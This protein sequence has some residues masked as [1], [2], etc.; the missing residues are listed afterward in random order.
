MKHIFIL[1]PAAG[2][3]KAESHILPRILHAVK[4]AGVEYEIHRTLNKGDGEKYVR[5]AC[6]KSSCKDR[7]RF[8]AVGGDGTLNEVANGAY[9]FN[10][11][12]ITVIPAGTDNDFVRIFENTEDFQDISKQLE[13]SPIPI[14]LLKCGQRY[15]VNMVNIGLD[16][17]IAV[18]ASVYKE[19][20]FT[21]GSLAYIA[22][23]ISLLRSNQGIE[24][25]ASIGNTDEI[26]GEFTLLAIGNGRFCG[27]GFMSM[28]NAYID[29]GLLDIVLVDKVSRRAFVAFIGKYRQ[30]THLNDSRIKKVLGY[31]QSDRIFIEPEGGRMGICIDGEFTKCSTLEVSIEHNAIMFSV[32]KKD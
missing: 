1:N 5:Q 2:N 22:G 9:G 17:E 19:G 20:P 12:E 32:P 23:A 26:S 18:K 11:A 10:N 25:S 7:I 29:D 8:Y 15:A 28:P 6:I 3:K 27:G 16:C 14:D 24:L 13:G 30:G 31:Y 4:S 21:K